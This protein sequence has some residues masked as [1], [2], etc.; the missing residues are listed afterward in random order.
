ME[1]DFKAVSKTLPKVYTVGKE[2][3][4]ENFNQPVN[5]FRSSLKIPSNILVTLNS[6]IWHYNFSSLGGE[7]FI[8]LVT[9]SQLLE[10]FEGR[11]P[12]YVFDSW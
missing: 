8:H 4:F 2:G 9:L 3:C 12:L 5:S 7:P 10:I 1:N 6:L 11:V